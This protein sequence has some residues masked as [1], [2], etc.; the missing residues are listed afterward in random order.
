[1]IIPSFNK[2]KNVTDSRYSLVVLVS[3]RA[4]KIVDGSAPLVNTENEKPVSIAIEEIMDKSILF[5]EPMS[6][7][8]YNKKIE[9][10]KAHKLEIL[11]N[12]RMKK[13]KDEY[14]EN[15]KIEDEIND[16]EVNFKESMSE[17]A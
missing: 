11:K 17:N 5:G 15:S 6:D 2:I 16:E 14:E 9:D 8:A 13:M 4:R 12:S 7:R 10:E 3:K 1:M